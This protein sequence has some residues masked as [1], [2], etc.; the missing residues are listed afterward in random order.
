VCQ[1]WGEDFGSRTGRKEI[2]VIPR[3]RGEGANFE[4]ASEE[5]EWEDMKWI[6]LAEDVDS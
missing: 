3:L 5:T 1:A 6:H 2:F 4:M